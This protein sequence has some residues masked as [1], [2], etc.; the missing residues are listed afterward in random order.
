MCDARPPCRPPPTAA[1]G[2]QASPSAHDYAALGTSGTEYLTIAAG[3]GVIG[4][5]G[6]CALGRTCPVSIGVFGSQAG[7]YT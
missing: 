3:D 1:G 7:M 2:T 5:P 6:K 4:T